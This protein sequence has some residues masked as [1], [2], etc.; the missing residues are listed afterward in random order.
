MNNSEKNL[1]KYIKHNRE[2]ALRE[3]FSYLKDKEYY[4]VK[5]SEDIMEEIL[6]K[7]ISCDC[8]NGIRKT[9]NTDICE[10]IN[11]ENS[12]LYLD[13]FK[14]FN[15]EN[16]SENGVELTFD[17][18]KL[19]RIWNSDKINKKWNLRNFY[20]SKKNSYVNVS[21]MDFN[22]VKFDNGVFFGKMQY[23][24][25]RG[26]KDLKIDLD[27]CEEN[28]SNTDFA[29]VDLISIDDMDGSII[30]GKVRNKLITG[31]SFRDIKGDVVIYP[32]TIINKDCSYVDFGSSYIG[33]SGKVDDLDDII[34]HHAN[35]SDCK[36]AV[37]GDTMASCKLNP[38]KVKDKN[39]RFVRFGRV[40]FTDNFDGCSI[41]YSKFNNSIGA[42]ID[43]Q[44][45]I[46]KDL[47][48]VDFADTT[49]VGS[50][51]G[52]N[53]NSASFKGIKNKISIDLDKVIYNENTDFT[54]V[55][56]INN[57]FQNNTD[58]KEKMKVLS[59]FDN[60]RMN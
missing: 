11:G 55:N 1:L 27:F 15:Y 19:M 9:L 8:M 40:M 39:L 25:F 22:D 24:S 59:L 45:I 16:V 44:K 21:Y 6:F 29:S 60:A 7:E 56:I 38:Q 35:L 5:F 46:A 51:D 53:L 13:L 20:H 32:G 3:L 50:F 10:L 31:A 30:R 49:V 34:I 2:I 47:S 52:C 17:F 28:I 18:V 33:T 54:D 36:V 23:T 43:P 14:K 12:E 37:F 42:I 26:C 58:T 4:S 41:A 57:R 48:G